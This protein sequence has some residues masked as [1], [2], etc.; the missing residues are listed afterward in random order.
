[1]IHYFFYL[2]SRAIG[3]KFVCRIPDDLNSFIFLGAPHTSNHDFIPSMA[4]VHVMAR[5][6]RFVIKKEWMK[7]PMGLIMK[8]MGGLGLD[9]DKLKAT[10]GSTTDIMAKLFTEH[11]ELVLMISPEG[12]RKPNSNWKTGFY[13][14]A[15]KANI[16]IV[17][18]YA[19]Y[20]KKE[21]GLGPVIYP[22]DFDKDM[23]AIMKFYSGVTAKEPRNF[24]LDK[25]FWE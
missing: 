21:A 12:T 19:D 18:G 16:P 1:M 24:K 11:P 13:Y 6:S 3:W 9:R 25:K 10:Q 22:T 2:L 7:F 14:I 17:L 20:K 23:R 15:Q 8:P 4:L 5:H